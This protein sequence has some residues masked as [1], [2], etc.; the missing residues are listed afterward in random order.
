MSTQTEQAIFKKLDDINTK[1]DRMDVKLSS[2][3]AVDEVKTE[4][5]DAAAKV[6]FGNGKLGLNAKMWIVWTLLGGLGF[7]VVALVVNWVQNHFA[8]CQI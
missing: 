7:V 2:F 3:M 6:V 8:S 4:I 1:V 5:H